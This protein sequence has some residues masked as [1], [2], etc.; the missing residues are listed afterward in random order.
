MTKPMENH[1][2]RSRLRVVCMFSTLGY[3]IL[4]LSLH[5]CNASKC[6]SSPSVRLLCTQSTRQKHTTASKGFISAAFLGAL[7]AAPAGGRV[8]N[9]I[10]DKRTSSRTC[11]HAH[12]LVPA[13]SSM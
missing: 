10:F 4:N 7:E 11:V 2:Q 1:W 3:H 8:N 12:T 13:T 6:L 9:P 5:I